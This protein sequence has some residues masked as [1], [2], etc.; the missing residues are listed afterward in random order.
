M[1]WLLRNCFIVASAISIVAALACVDMHL[2][3]VEAKLDR[4]NHTSVALSQLAVA[5]PQ[6]A[7]R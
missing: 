7:L 5:I 1:K 3:R 2:D 6:G 4:A